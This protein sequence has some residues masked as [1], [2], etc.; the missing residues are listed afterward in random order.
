MDEKKAKLLEIKK[1]KMEEDLLFEERYRKNNEIQ[2]KP[3]KQKVDPNYQSSGVVGGVNPFSNYS[4]QN[5]V[6]NNVNS[7]GITQSQNK[8]LVES[9]YPD[10]NLNEFSNLENQDILSNIKIS[11]DLL[12]KDRMDKILMT[13]QKINNFASNPNIDLSHNMSGY[14]PPHQNNY[15]KSET[16]TMNNYHNINNMNS[17]NNPSQSK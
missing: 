7:I 17:M 11:Q 14:Y 13:E 10:Q 3:I 15:I 16:P 1:K 9:P 2:E 6:V 12:N 4:Q 5:K 8:L